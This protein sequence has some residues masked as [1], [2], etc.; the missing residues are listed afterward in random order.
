MAPAR[1]LGR[2]N[3]AVK[4]FCRPGSACNSSGDARVRTRASLCSSRPQA[5]SA[6]KDPSA[7]IAPARRCWSTLAPLPAA[8][9]RPWRCRSILSAAGFDLG[10]L[11]EGLLPIIEA[12]AYHRAMVGDCRDGLCGERCNRCRAR[13]PALPLAPFSAATVGPGGRDRPRARAYRSCRR[14]TGGAGPR[15]KRGCQARG[16]RSCGVHGPAR[17]LPRGAALIHGATPSPPTI[18]DCG[19]SKISPKSCERRSEIRCRLRT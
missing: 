11:W 1:A 5:S 9:W 18:T 12:A 14:G 10:A 16:A 15:R 13:P 4:P 8:C 7:A 6:C 2:R 17:R 3:A 19:A